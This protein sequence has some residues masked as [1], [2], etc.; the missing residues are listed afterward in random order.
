MAALPFRRKERH[1]L[2][3]YRAKRKEKPLS[4]WSGFPGFIPDGMQG[5]GKRPFWVYFGMTMP[6]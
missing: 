3:V 4:G 6:N 2:A 1:F 5:I